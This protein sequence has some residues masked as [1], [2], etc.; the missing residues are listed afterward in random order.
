MAIWRQMKL[1]IIKLLVH[2][3]IDLEQRLTS[4]SCTMYNLEPPTA[5]HKQTCLHHYTYQGLNNHWKITIQW[6][7]C[8]HGNSSSKQQNQ[9]QNL[10]NAHHGV[11]TYRVAWRQ[12]TVFQLWYIL[13]VANTTIKE[14]RC[15]LISRNWSRFPASQV[16]LF[17]ELSTLNS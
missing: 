11:K 5:E 10:Q 13:H 8:M 14:H 7:A 17:W 4:C 2:V 6:V 1:C 9:T 3:Q 12:N 15:L 16:R